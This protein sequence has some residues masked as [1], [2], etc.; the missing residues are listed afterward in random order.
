MSAIARLFKGP[1]IPKPEPAPPVPTVDDARAGID[2]A[3]QRRLMQGRAAT[4]LVNDESGIST[5][6]KVLTG[7]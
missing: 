2:D 1:K 6:A 4:R 5:A 7:N 3:R